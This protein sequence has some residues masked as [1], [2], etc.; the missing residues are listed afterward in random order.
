MRTW[1]AVLGAVLFSGAAGALVTLPRIGLLVAGAV[2]AITAGLFVPFRA[3]MT[4]LVIV[5]G[6]TLVQI[7]VAGIDLRLDIALVPTALVACAA[8]GKFRDLTQWLWHP[9]VQLLW[10]YLI[11]HLISS[12]VFSPDTGA[13]LR[14]VAWQVLNLM[15]VG[16]A[17]AAF[18]RE[19]EHIQRL[20]LCTAAV[21]AGSGLL[22]WG[23]ATAAGSD[24][25]GA[26]GTAGFGLR[27]HG[28]AFEPNILG[29]T[30]AFWA[31][32]LLTGGNLSSARKLT[33]GMLL[34]CLP[35]T[36]TRAAIA[37]LA[38][39]LVIYVLRKPGMMPRLVPV[40]VA[41]GVA[42][43]FVSVANPG[44]LTAMVG[45]LTAFSFTDQTATYRFTSWEIAVE[46]LDG[47]NWLIGMGTNSF[48]QRHLDPT[49]LEEGVGY[50]LG[51]LP[52]QTLYD[53]GLIGL[54]L[55]IAAG[56]S[57][58]KLGDRARRLALL[59]AFLVISVATSPFFF[60]NWWL[61][62]ALALAGQDPAGRPAS[63]VQ[64]APAIA[65]RSVR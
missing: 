52:I 26:N 28:F 18:G 10:A 4:V 21:V 59:A 16:L 47:P 57:L 38:V 63:C 25:W 33:L 35:L 45:K 19:R 61:L 56:W 54:V 15:I 36:S 30:V 8:A 23:L 64:Q 34:L 32:V 37:A 39:G 3:V 24:N 48:E 31:L 29:A 5:S 1:A 12:A 46:E 13:S 43:A 17:L 60:A 22:A 7:P 9:T 51:S 58:V 55:L 53:T 50:Y 42:F 62:I 49:L 65:S 6:F 2:V 27:A 14:V 11:L 41:G 44:S 20:L 40:L